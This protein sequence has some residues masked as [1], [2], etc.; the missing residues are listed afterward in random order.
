[1][2]GKQR[3]TL[4]TIL[5][6]IMFCLV[7]GAPT[8]QAAWPDRPVKLIVPFNP[9]GGT[10]QQARMIEKE[11]QQEFGQPLTFVYKPGADGAIGGTELADSPA[12]GY[13]IAVYTFPLFYMNELTNKGRYTTESF[14]YLAISSLDVPVLVTR[15][16]SDIKD[17]KDFMERA[18]ASG[19]KKLTV[20]SVETLGPTHMAA[21]KLQQQNVP[22]NIVTMAGGAK[23]MA[24]V[25]GG[26]LDV[27]MTLKGAAQAS[28]GSLRYLAVA[29]PERDKELPD[30][31][32][33]AEFG[34]P[35]SSLGARIWLA[36]KG[37]P[38]EVKQ[39]LT[40]GFAKIYA[41]Q[42]V[43]ERH[44]AGG[45]PV[46]F[47]DGAALQNFVDQFKPEGPVLLKMYTDSK[48]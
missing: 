39:R 26:H 22:M 29:T 40:E 3:L 38:P 45:Q 18:K 8:A 7:L 44:L 2:R 20:G 36:P 25:L 9:G 16:E 23:G 43:Q 34:L 24:A 30:V 47:G 21:L 27:L 13:T 32:T 41:Q 1:M 17:F 5:G 6:F 15:K 37:L 14:D 10:D 33:I 42:A 11:F 12:D 35:V 4:G 46:S 48:K 19:Q 28:A 31:P